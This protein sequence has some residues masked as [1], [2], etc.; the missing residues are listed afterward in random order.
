MPRR[1]RFRLHQCVR[2]RERGRTAGASGGA[3]GIRARL[4]LQAK[5]LAPVYSKA[6]CFVA[7]IHCTGLAEPPLL[8]EARTALAE[9]IPQVAA[10]KAEEI[11]A[12]AEQSSEDRNSATFL[13]AQALY[14]LGQHEEALARLRPLVASGYE[15]AALLQGHV[16]AAEGKW[17]EAQMVYHAQSAM[18]ASEFVAPPSDDRRGGM[19]AGVGSQ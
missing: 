19:F 4:Y 2:E 17:K 9:A 5:A 14:Q 16:L 8:Q 13:L 12:R 18:P 15:G 10:T 3:T 6:F 1:R 11:L 7:G